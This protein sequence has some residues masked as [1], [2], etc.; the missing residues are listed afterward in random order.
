MTG[1]EKLGDREGPSLGWRT[2]AGRD[3]SRTREQQPALGSAATE[4][5]TTPWAAPASVPS[6]IFPPSPMSPW[7]LLIAVSPENAPQPGHV[8][9]P[10]LRAACPSAHTQGLHGSQAAKTLAVWVPSTSQIAP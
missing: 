8:V 5:S 2:S 6:L 4:T 10:T 9:L 1:Q 7:V 3:T